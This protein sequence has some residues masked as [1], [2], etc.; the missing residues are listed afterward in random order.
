[1]LP[2]F[3]NRRESSGHDAHLFMKLGTGRVNKTEYQHESAIRTRV[4]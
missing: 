3:M 4:C 1:V 2:G